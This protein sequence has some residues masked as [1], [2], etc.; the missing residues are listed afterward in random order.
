MLYAAAR[1]TTLRYNDNT[2]KVYGIESTDQGRWQETNFVFPA[3]SASWL[4]P[5]Y[6]IPPGNDRT[7]FSFTST[8][9]R[10]QI[11]RVINLILS[12]M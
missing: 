2:S 11:K 3:V 7:M 6:L 1:Y 12:N 9:N 5:D 10:L 4:V 8:R